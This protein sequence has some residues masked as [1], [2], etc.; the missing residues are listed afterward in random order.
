MLAFKIPYSISQA[1]EGTLANQQRKRAKNIYTYSQRAT[2]GRT[3]EYGVR[4]KMKM[5]RELSEEETVINTLPGLLR[6]LR[7]KS[8]SRWAVLCNT[9]ASGPLISRSR[10]PITLTAGSPSLPR[11]TSLARSHTYIYIHTYSY[12]VYGGRQG[13]RVAPFTFRPIQMIQAN[14]CHTVHTFVYLSDWRRRPLM[15]EWGVKYE[16]M[17]VGKREREDTSER[18][19][20]IQ[21]SDSKGFTLCCS[22][23]L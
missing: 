11:F 2:E 19:R 20:E 6:M 21:W 13:V 15:E 4:M 3:W 10:A 18:G 5:K 8:S 22:S 12:K 1:S 16:N 17:M 14:S 23:W 7:L 9:H